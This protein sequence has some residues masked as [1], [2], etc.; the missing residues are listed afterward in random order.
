MMQIFPSRADF[1]ANY[2]D[3]K[4]QIVYA[5]YSADFDTALSA[6][7]KIT[8]DESYSFLLES[9]EGGAHIGR[10]SIIACNPDVIWHSNDARGNPLDELRAHIKRCKIDIMPAHLPPACSGGMYGYLGYEMVRYVEPSVP[11]ENED[12]LDIPEGVMMRPR[13]LAV[14][15][16]VKHELT[17]TVPVLKNAAT[18]GCTADAAYD[19]A[20]QLLQE[21]IERLNTPLTQ[22]TVKNESALSAPLSLQRNFTDDGYADL[23]RAAK[24]HIFA[25][26]I[27]QIVPSQRFRAPFDLPAIDLYRALRRINPSPF[28][29][30]LK[31]DGFALV[32]SSPEIL[33][34]VQDGEV[35]VRPIA[36]T[37][38]RGKTVEEDAALAEDLLADQK[39]RAEHLMLIDLG[40]N[41][42]GRVAKIG[43]VRVTESFTIER[44]S[45]VMHI[46]SNVVG[47]LRDDLDCVDAL[48]SGFPAGTVSGAPKVSAMKLI[49]KF[50]NEKRRFYAGC[51]GYFDGLGNMNT[52][53]AL[54]TA[55]V[56][57]GEI[58]LQA[59]A[60]IV[61]DSI[62]ESENQECI[63]KAMALMKAAEAAIKF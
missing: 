49:H 35:T 5:H 27:F 54:R 33:V 8:K 48:F 60:G 37:R 18:K 19:E 15:D 26:D 62:P 63:N 42:V 4:T 53:I 12:T 55:L 40:R 51:V 50:E 10:Y 32:G 14:F 45:H 38:P 30:H 58:V 23:V 13:L 59:G 46:V 21:A 57:D 6:Y 7:Y 52:C 11:N 3:G 47:Q 28:L 43:T 36:G 34:R 39:E 41:D 17:L 22:R 29:F 56:K 1:T 9:V 16:N 31:M 24:E 44:Y 2:N 25:G 61:A 20:V